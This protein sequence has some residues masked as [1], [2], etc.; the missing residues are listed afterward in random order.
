MA[1]RTTD[2]SA[3]QVVEHDFL[4]PRNILRKLL[5][6][7]FTVAGAEWLGVALHAI[8]LALAR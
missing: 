2:V 5:S 4:T 3:G 7:N 8:S 1:S 6:Y